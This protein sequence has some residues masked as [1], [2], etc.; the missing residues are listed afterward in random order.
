MLTQAYVQV[1]R[2]NFELEQ[3]KEAQKQLENQL[4]QATEDQETLETQL[5][6]TGHALDQANVEVSHI[7]LSWF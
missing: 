2:T 4:A 6:E 1:E 7:M 3:Y 5:Y